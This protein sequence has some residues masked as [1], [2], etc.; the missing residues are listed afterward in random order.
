MQREFDIRPKIYE[1]LFVDADVKVRRR[2]MSIFNKGRNAF[3]SQQEYDDYLE[4]RE[5]LIQELCVP[6]M[7]REQEAEAKI[8]KYLAENSAEQIKRHNHETNTRLQ[9]ERLALQ[10]AVQ[11]RL[12]RANN[13]VDE[14]PPERAN[15]DEQVWG[16]TLAHTADDNPLYTYATQSLQSHLGPC[17]PTEA[18]LVEYLQYQPDAAGQPQQYADFRVFGFSRV[19]ACN[20]MFIAASDSLFA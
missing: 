10:R 8:K 17:V 13:V 7:Q 16:D 14:S 19:D 20:K 12:D 18:E 2:I 5:D 9:Q 3:K 1:D 11:Q 6:S 4:D 15:L